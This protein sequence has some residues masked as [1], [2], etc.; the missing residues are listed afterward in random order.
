M[1][2]GKRPHLAP[3]EFSDAAARTS[4]ASAC[5]DIRLRCRPWPPTPI[6][7]RSGP[8]KFRLPK[9]NS[10]T[11]PTLCRI[12][13]ALD[14]DRVRVFTAYEPPARRRRRLG[15][16]SVSCL[17][18][19]ADRAADFGVTLAVQNHHDVAVD[20]DALLEFARGNRSAER[21]DCIR[22]LV[23]CLARRRSRTSSASGAAVHRHHDQR[24][25][26][27]LAAL[28][29]SQRTGELRAAPA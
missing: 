6:S 1:L 20:T 16:W 27:P 11:S 5:G 13:S 26:H 9:C 8:P 14:A 2:M 15:S 10:T 4:C 17:R 28:S 19:C 7:R 29:L 25:L 22:C 18:E 12:A 24:R 23:A 21:Q 3:R